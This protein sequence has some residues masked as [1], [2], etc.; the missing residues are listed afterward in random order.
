MQSSSGI[1]AACNAESPLLSATTC[2]VPDA[3][4]PFS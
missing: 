2:Q 1:N 3:F 4:R